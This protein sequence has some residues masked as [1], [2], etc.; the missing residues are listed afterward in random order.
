MVFTIVPMVIQIVVFLA[1]PWIETAGGA[2]FL[3][4]LSTFAAS[5]LFSGSVVT[6]N[7]E[8]DPVNAAVVL[9]VFN[10]SAQIAGFLGPILMAVFTDTEDKKAGWDKFFYAMAGS[11][12][13]GIVSIVFAVWVKPSEWKNRSKSGEPYRRFLEKNR[14]IVHPYLPNFIFF[15]FPRFGIPIAMIGGM[16][17]KNCTVGEELCWSEQ[18]KANVLGAYF[19]GYTAMFFSV[20]IVKRLNVFLS[21]YRVWLVLC[22]ATQ[23]SYPILAQYS[24]IWLIVA[25]AARGFLTGIMICYNMEFINNW[26]PDRFRGS[27]ISAIGFIASLGNGTS[28]LF[29]STFTDNFGWQYYFY[30]CGTLFTL[31]LVLNV[32]F[33]ARTP[34]ESFLMKVF[35]SKQ[36]SGSKPVPKQRTKSS[37]RDILSR[38]YVWM[39]CV[40]SICF[41]LP[42]YHTLGTSPFYLSQ[43]LKVDTQTI[44]LITLCL[45]M[46]VAAGTVFFSWLFQ[47]LDKYL[48]WLTCRLTFCIVPMIIQIVI[49]LA[50]PHIKTVEGATVLLFIATFSASQYFSGSVVT[51]SMEIDPANAAVVMSI[52]NG[53]A[54]I[55]W[56]LGPTLMAVFTDTEDKKAGWDKFFY[57]MAG[58]AALGIV[59]IVFAVWV[60]PSEWKNR[61]SGMG[62]V[63]SIGKA[64][65]SLT[66]LLAVY[67][68]MSARFG[69]PIAMIGGMLKK[70]CTVGEELCW[71]EQTKANVLGAYF[72]G[73]T[74]MFFSVSIVKRF[75]VFLSGYRVWLVL[76][77]A[78]QFSYPILA[79]YSTIWLI[80]A[81]AARGFLT[82]I[83]ICYNMEFINNWIPDRF[84]GSFISAIGFITYL[85][86][87]TSGLFAST[88]TDNFGWQYYFYFCGTLFTLVLVLN[89]LFV[90]RTPEESFLMKVFHPKQESGSKPVPKQQT[91][92]SIRDIL[93]RWYVWMFCV[94][95]ISYNLAYYHI[96]STSPFY[97]NE[98]LKVDTQTISLITLCL[99]ITTAFGTLFFSWLFQKLDNY[100]SWLTCRLTFCIVPMSVQIVI[101]LAFPHIKTVEGATV[102]LVIATFSA[103]QY[104]S[105]SVVT[106]SMEIDPA[107]AAVVMSI[108]NGAAQI[109]GFL[110]PTLMAVFI[111][112]EDKKAGWDKFFY[113]MAGS[114]ALGIVSIVFAVW[115]KPSEWKNRSKSGEPYRVKNGILSNDIV[116]KPVI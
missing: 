37:I 110:G 96:L 10:G 33:V 112:T 27:F 17:K 30:F 56:F 109:A 2:T 74:A 106:A 98:V 15:P 105:G 77:I 60:K 103:S 47:K 20:S 16:L 115:V 70:N 59:S 82:G 73:Y 22:I 71:S 88:F 32:L 67:N 89:V 6:A 61:R 9:S 90:A 75:N 49:Y 63:E 11:A 80:V 31:V 86:N 12:A 100:V 43:V 107:N 111:D 38:W 25:Q 62:Y 76:C 34:E 65:A 92:S 42:Y 102:L 84:R 29:A 93:S 69:I 18:T 113:A 40:Y 104:F 28:G 50:F 36:E 91:T 55:A 21:G 13:L 26:I 99:C 108:F 24:T 3:L 64:L 58:F 68:E 4:V 46:T 101:F 97:L 53:A 72:Y 23:F 116:L 114:A 81:Q 45:S 48:S 85:G 52:F 1:F 35:H 95:G 14:H 51:A 87:G 57:A 54:Q 44:S 19:Y 7:M 8:I 5:T 94:Y 41:S 39:F 79:Q 78:T 83:M 66:C